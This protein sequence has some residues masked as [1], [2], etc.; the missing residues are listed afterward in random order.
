[1]TMFKIPAVAVSAFT[2][3]D[4]F[5]DFFIKETYHKEAQKSRT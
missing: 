2:G 5:V 3:I 1:L 4:I